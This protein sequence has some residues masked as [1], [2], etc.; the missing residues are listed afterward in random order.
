MPRERDHVGYVTDVI[1]HP[2]HNTYKT[3]DND[4]D[5]KEKKLAGDTR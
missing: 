3:R 1:W 2:L 5:N 4:R